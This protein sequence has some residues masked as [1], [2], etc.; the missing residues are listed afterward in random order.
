MFFRLVLWCCDDICMCL[1]VRQCFSV[2]GLFVMGWLGC[3]SIIIGLVSSGVC[4]MVGD[5]GSRMF[6]VVLMVLVSNLVFSCW[7]FLCMV[8]MLMCGVFLVMVVMS[9]GS[10][11]VFS[12]LC[13]DSVKW[14]LFVVG[15]KCVFLCKVCLKFCSVVCI[16]VMS[17]CVSG[18]GIMFW[19]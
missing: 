13:I 3:V 11:V 18:V 15:L 16:L 10:N 17:V 14:C 8:V 5:V 19:L 2:S 7:W 12:V 6:V 9:G 1:Y 4:W